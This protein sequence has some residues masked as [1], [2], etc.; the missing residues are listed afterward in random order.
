MPEWYQTRFPSAFLVLRNL[1]RLNTRQ[2]PAGRRIR[3]E[4]TRRP[5]TLPAIWTEI[6]AKQPLRR[7]LLELFEAIHHSTCPALELLLQLLLQV[8]ETVGHRGRPEEPSP[9]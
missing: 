9:A 8:M 7:S 1:R 4:M 6:R 3:G 2:D 5:G